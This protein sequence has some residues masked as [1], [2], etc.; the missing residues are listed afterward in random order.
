MV[1]FIPAGRRQGYA[2][3]V[4]AGGSGDDAFTPLSPA[5]ARIR[6]LAP[7]T[8][9]EPVFCIFSSL[10]KSASGNFIQRAGGGKRGFMHQPRQPLLGL[11]DI[12]LALPPAVPG[13]R[14]SDR[15]SRSARQRRFCSLFVTAFTHPS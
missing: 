11:P 8:L 7:L 9:K 12:P 15:I 5:S 2:L 6:L 10:R 14:R 3:R 4:V 1:E 13:R